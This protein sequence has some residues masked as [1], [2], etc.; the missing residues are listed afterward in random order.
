MLTI[1]EKK[2]RKKENRNRKQL[3]LLLLFFLVSNA[4]P[5]YVEYHTTTP[6]LYSA[7]YSLLSTPPPLLLYRHSQ[8]GQIKSSRSIQSR[9]INETENCLGDSQGCF[10]ISERERTSQKPQTTNHKQP[11]IWTAISNPFRS[12][13][14]ISNFLTIVKPGPPKEEEEEEEQKSL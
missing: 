13:T 2:E 10:G 6:P 4:L 14:S 8:F 3:L 7:L 5:P 1:E 11:Q 9:Q 12:R